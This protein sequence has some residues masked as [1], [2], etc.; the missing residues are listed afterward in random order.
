MQVLK[1]QLEEEDYQRMVSN[2]DLNSPYR[3]SKSTKARFVPEF[4][5]LQGQIVSIFNVVLVVG[6]AFAFGYKAIEYSLEQ[7]DII[8]VPIIPP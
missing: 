5:T 1:A 8:K 7:P 2:V 6:G 3:Q 4:K